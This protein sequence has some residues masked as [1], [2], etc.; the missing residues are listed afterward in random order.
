MKCYNQTEIVAFAVFGVGEVTSVDNAA[1]VIFTN[2]LGLFAEE[3]S[4]R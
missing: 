3:K 1:N 2:V 4:M